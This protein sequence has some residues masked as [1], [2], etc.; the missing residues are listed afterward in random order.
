M[1]GT[2]GCRCTTNAGADLLELLESAGAGGA[3]ESESAIRVRS[4]ANTIMQLIRYYVSPRP[5]SKPTQCVRAHID[6]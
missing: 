4:S 2:A 5:A 3:P 1:I 6:E